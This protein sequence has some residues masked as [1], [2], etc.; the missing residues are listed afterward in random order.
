MAIGI[1]FLVIGVALLPFGIMYFKQTWDQFREQKL[2]LP[3]KILVVILEIFSLFTLTAGFATWLLSISL[4][5]IIF[6]IAVI[7][8]VLQG[9]M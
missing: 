8:S 7:Y 9:V 2:S 1:I 6:G 5:C 3:R 4:I